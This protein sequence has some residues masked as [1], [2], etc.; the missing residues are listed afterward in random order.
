MGDGSI[1]YLVIIKMDQVAPPQ[2]NVDS[3]WCRNEFFTM[4]IIIITIGQIKSGDGRRGG[5]FEMLFV[6][7]LLFK[8]RAHPPSLETR[9]ST[10]LLSLPPTHPNPHTLFA[11]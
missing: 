9:D 1:G 8:A 6:I 4:I 3:C 5:Q 2:I 7:L 10:N 11:R